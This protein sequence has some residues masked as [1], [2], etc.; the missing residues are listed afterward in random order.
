M[1]AMDG[2][3]AI[4]TGASAGIG[5]ATAHAFAAEGASVVVSD[6]DVAR[7]E[8]VAST[9]EGAGGK[10][11]FVRADVSGAADVGALVDAAVEQF[12]RL[13]YAFNN[14]GI[15]GDPAPTADCPRE[16]WD[17][18]L[19]V[20]LTGVFLCMQAE[21]PRILESGGGAIVNC[22]SIAGLVGFPAAPA[23]V[24]SKHGVVGLTRSAALELAPQGLRVNAVCPGVIDTEMVAR[25]AASQPDV[26][27]QVVAAHPVGRLGQPEEVAATVVWLCSEAAAFIT[28]QA[29]AVDGGYTTH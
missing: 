14:A 8:A 11:V 28:G 21:I 27:D 18:I 24:A 20:N 12:G 9:I 29:I 2:K 17:R 1:G 26:I 25:S 4:V 6:I 16:T 19:S 15:E 23:Y 10:A 7:G 13:D 22:A 3:V 5:A